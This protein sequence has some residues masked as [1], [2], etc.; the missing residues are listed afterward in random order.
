MT[1]KQQATTRQ[2]AEEAAAPLAAL[3]RRKF[4]RATLW[5]AAGAA[6]VLAGGFVW[7]RR[8][9]LDKLP[10]PAHLQ[11]LSA[12]EYH[13]F[14]RAIVVLLPTEGTTLT[15]ADQVPIIDNIDHLLGLLEPSIRK[16]LGVGLSL[17][18]NA[19]VLSY[20][21]RFVDL[22]LADAIRFC[23]DWSEGNTIQRTLSSVLKKFVYMSYWREPATWAPIQFDGPVSDR[24]GIPSLGNTALPAELDEASA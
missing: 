18:D 7:L 11:H 4:L 22:E 19:A 6:A 8:S 23:D 5:G 17:L 9:P 20:G 16:D 24:W 10:A 12:S 15:P 1:T 2:Q 14:Q 3:S 21:R 13:L